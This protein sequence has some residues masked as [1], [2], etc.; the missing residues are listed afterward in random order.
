MDGFNFKSDYKLLLTLFNYNVTAILYNFGVR[1]P[2]VI[3]GVK[4]FL[5]L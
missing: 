3:K 4:Y 2:H 5:N 1:T